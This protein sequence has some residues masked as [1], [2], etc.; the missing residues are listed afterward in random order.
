MGGAGMNED[1]ERYGNLLRLIEHLHR[2][3]RTAWIAANLAGF[4]A[5]LALFTAILR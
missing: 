3:V 1:D 2:Q 4:I 5:L